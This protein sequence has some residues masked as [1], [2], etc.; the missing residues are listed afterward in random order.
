VVDK[1]VRGGTDII[2]ASTTGY[3][4]ANV[5]A[6]Y[7]NVVLGLSSTCGSTNRAVRGGGMRRGRRVMPVLT[8]E[9]TTPTSRSG[10]SGF[11]QGR[12]ECVTGF[13]LCGMST[14]RA[15]DCSDRG[16]CRQRA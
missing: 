10:W 6:H 8:S 3:A 9:D 13:L 11:A 5:S 7:K 2:G 15:T 4:Q 14:A 1:R 12:S 16:E